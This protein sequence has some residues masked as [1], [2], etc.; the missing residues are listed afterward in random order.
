MIGATTLQE[1][2]KHIEKDAA[3][4]RRFQPVMVDEPSV[5]DAIS[6]PPRRRTTRLHRL[7]GRR[8]AHRGGPPQ[9]VLRRLVR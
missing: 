1:Y 8:P 9:A 5:E 7:R 2:R 3:L 4:E 6:Q